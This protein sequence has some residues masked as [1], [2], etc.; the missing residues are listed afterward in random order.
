MTEA[1]DGTWRTDVLS[2]PLPLLNLSSL[3]MLV[4]P[5]TRTVALWVC[6]PEQMHTK[7]CNGYDDSPRMPPGSTGKCIYITQACECIRWFVSSV[8]SN[9]A[10]WTVGDQEG[11]CA[12]LVYQAGL[13]MG[14]LGPVAEAHNLNLRWTLDTAGMVPSDTAVKWAFDNPDA[15][16]DMLDLA[17]AYSSRLTGALQRTVTAWGC[18]YSLLFGLRIYVRRPS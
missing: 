6:M 9:Q 1:V 11:G 5:S 13:P 2:E 17:C 15:G 18:E 8:V 16:I 7:H 4:A 12:R 3:T 10:G 14:D